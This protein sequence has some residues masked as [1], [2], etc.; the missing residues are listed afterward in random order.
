MKAD[1]SGASLR[2]ANLKGA[3]LSQAN[4]GLADLSGADLQDAN[5]TLANLTKADLS[6]ANL[7]GARLT[8]ANLVQVDLRRAN[9]TS[10]HIYGVS[11]W[12]LRLSG[13]K[14]QNLIITAQDEPEVT[15]DNIEVGQLVHLLLNNEK[16][17]DFI[18]ALTSKIVLVLGRFTGEREVTLHALQDELRRRDYLPIVFDFDRPATLT[19]TESISL[20]ARMARFVIA[21]ISDAK[22]LLQELHAIIPDNPSVPVQPL[23]VTPQEEPGMFDFF[24]LYPWVLTPHRYANQYQLIADLDAR[25]IRPAESKVR[26]L[27]SPWQAAFPTTSASPPRR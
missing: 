2:Y 17:R 3:D 8:F 12:G 19:T 5:L 4:L 11:A 14:Q 7:Y 24:R 23:I 18:G 21:D 27:R 10:C 6:Q 20:L 16:V 22:S 25:V 26:E 13:A 9:L 1:L 15:V